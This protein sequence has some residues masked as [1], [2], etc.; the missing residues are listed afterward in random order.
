MKIFSVVLLSVFLLASCG[1]HQKNLEGS[2]FQSYPFHGAEHFIY[3]HL[4]ETGNFLL[5]RYI[6]SEEGTDYSR[7]SGKWFCG[8]ENLTLIYNEGDLYSEGEMEEFV[9]KIQDDLLIWD[10]EGNISTNYRMKFE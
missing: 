10:F 1:Y 9:Y 6:E 8:K 5:E 7:D 4:N 3:L 2:Y